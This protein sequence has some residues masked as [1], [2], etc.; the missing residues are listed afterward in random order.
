MNYTPLKHKIQ[1][2]VFCGV[3]I[4]L[5]NLCFSYLFPVLPISELG[6]ASA[7]PPVFGLLFGPWGALGSAV[8]YLGADILSGDPPEI[9][10]VYFFV[11]FLYGYIPY[12]LWYL[13]G[14]DK[15]ISPP[16][17]DNVRNLT[18]FVGIMFVNA[19]VMAGFLGF[20][21]DGLGLYELVSLTTIIFAL[22]NFDFSIMFG[23]L[24]VI[25]ANYYGISMIKPRI[26]GKT[27][28]PLRL[29]DALAVVAV[30]TGMINVLYSFFSGPNLYS[31]AAGT[32]TYSLALIYIWKPVTRNIRVKKGQ[33][34][35]SLTERLI[36][37]FIIIGAIVAVVSGILSFSSIP[38]VQGAE[39]K[40]WELV[41]L[42]TTL[43]LSIFY[44]SVI[45]LLGYIEKTM[46]IPIES[47]S[48]IVN[49]Y[50]SD[51]DGIADSARIIAKCQEY[52]SDVTEVGIL[53]HSFQNMIQE[54]EVYLEN[55]KKVTSEKEKI[56]TELNVARKI[57]A[58]ML[59]KIR[60]LGARDEFN[61][62][63]TNLPARE[64][65]GDFYDFFM[66]DDH[67]LAVVIGDVSGKGVP[68]AL[69][70][71]IAKTLIKNQAQLG[72]TPEE[73]FSTVN[74]QLVEGNDENMF[75]TAWMGI[76]ETST[77]KFTY[78]NAGHNPP[79]LKQGAGDYQW[80]KS[81]PGFILGGLDDTQYQ[82]GEIHMEPGDR[83]YL[84]TDGV[85]E[86]IDADEELFGEGRLL[87]AVNSYH[88]PGLKEMCSHILGRMDG[89]VEGQEQF[90]DITMLV[91]E[92]KEK[93]GDSGR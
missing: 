22:N 25:G 43:I 71:V 18:K 93:T 29:Y 90:D 48:D 17:L 20:I 87:E 45:V 72:K 58:D 77:G 24:V 92:Y 53:A 86:A 80:L 7:L 55:L 36:L 31:L 66:V 85:T 41:Y 34:R 81:K 50:V 91:L 83:V 62:Y 23:T 3:V 8:G 49:N 51:S 57:Q 10:L 61:I 65:G 89:F 70:M 68:A 84:Y 88:G 69:F 26:S 6:P 32:L 35:V 16:S 2:M 11:Q 76:L 38:F 40:S 78:V 52:A 1:K 21:L 74:N 64:V 63:A 5:I 42:H 47:L 30:V 9:Y 82:Q 14:R 28:I 15:T 27:R 13:L 33:V 44:I 37:I 4:F 60:T 39:I 67:H 75:V 59:P 79:L 19:V 12:K 56:N 54:L 73:V 46:T